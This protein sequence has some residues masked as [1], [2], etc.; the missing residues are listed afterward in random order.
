MN[1]D[2]NSIT[3]LR[4]MVLLERTPGDTTIGSL[5]LS[6]TSTTPRSSGTVLQIGPGVDSSTIQVGDLAIIDTTRLTT[7]TIN[8]SEYLCVDYS[9]I[10]GIVTPTG[11]IV[12]L[13]DRVLL[14]RTPADSAMGSLL[15]SES[16][17]PEKS[18]GTILALGGTVP[19]LAVGDKVVFDKYGGTTLE[20]EGT[21]LV[22][23]NSTT[24]IARIN[25]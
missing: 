5:V 20:Y 22:V 19:G 18:T 4:S 10:I 25:S 6:S 2:S 17:T 15:L 16:T 3:L 8:D 21:T 13:G 12:P 1:S 24:I 9:A 14:D 7:L 11:T 23:V